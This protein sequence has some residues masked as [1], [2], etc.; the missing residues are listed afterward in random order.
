MTLQSMILCAGDIELGRVNWSR[1]LELAK[2]LSKKTNKD[3][4]IL[5]QEIPGCSTCKNYGKNVLS[6]PLVVEAIEDLFIP[7]VV[8]NNKQGKD[9]EI[10]DFFGEPAWNNPVVRIV[11]FQ[12]KDVTERLNGN[13]SSYGLISKMNYTLIKRNKK[14]PQYL[15][16]LEEE[17][18]AQASG[19]ETAYIGMYCFWSGEKCFSQA[20]GVV[21]THAGFI[22]GS[23]VV[24][25]KYNPVKTSLEALIEH[26]KE[27]KC[28]DRL[29]SEKKS[30]HNS[31]ISNHDKGNFRLDHESKYYIYNS[32]YR[33]LPMTET[34][35][36]KVNFALANGKSPDD[37][38]SNRQIERYKR[39]LKLEESKLTSV[40]G[41]NMEQEW[42]SNKN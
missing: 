26:G 22:N 2:E 13:Y 37:Y 32:K 1:D 27:M 18:L 25:I 38:L 24:E 5:F 33:F 21:E 17:F 31:T 6:H 35:A 9:K 11:D 10:L 29:Y 7:V 28:A 4:L 14:L 12:L 8:H 36:C 39:I 34:Q 20:Q 30:K 15:S 16:L 3:I 40:I 41:K 42:Y 19:V 23:E